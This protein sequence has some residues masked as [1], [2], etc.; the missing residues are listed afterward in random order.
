MRKE[1]DVEVVGR[2]STS[3]VTGTLMN[4]GAVDRSERNVDVVDEV[5]TADPA[6]LDGTGYD[7][8]ATH[9]SILVDVLIAR[10]LA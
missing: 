4:A 5:V 10:F 8:V 9:V 3:V 1:I 6:A 2:D 7:A